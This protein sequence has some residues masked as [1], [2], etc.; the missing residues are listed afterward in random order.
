MLGAAFSQIGMAA[1]GGYATAIGAGV[2]GTP[3]PSAIAVTPNQLSPGFVT[4]L[5]SDVAAGLQ[6][7]DN[8]LGVGP[9]ALTNAINTGGQAVGSAAGTVVTAT[10]TVG[11]WALIMAALIAAIVIIPRI[12]PER[13]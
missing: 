10:K 9:V 6:S 5:G 1:G 12:L 8:V 13:R 7:V 3:I 4:Q 2:A 11:E